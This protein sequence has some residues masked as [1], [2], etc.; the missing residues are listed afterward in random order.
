[1]KTPEIAFVRSHANAQLLTLIKK[2]YEKLKAKALFSR[3]LPK[4]VGLLAS[5]CLVLFI[6]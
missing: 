1:M 4:Q 5:G 2:Y 6:W 3:F